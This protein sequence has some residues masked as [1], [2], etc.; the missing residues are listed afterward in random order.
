MPGKPVSIGHRV[1]HGAETFREAVIIDNH[2]V[3]ASKTVPAW[4]PFT[5]PLTL[6]E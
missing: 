3:E 2:V 4:R 1:V 6:Q 5:T